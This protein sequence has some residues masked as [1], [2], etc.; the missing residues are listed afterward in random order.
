MYNLNLMI[1]YSISVINLLLRYI[2]MK[3]KINLLILKKN[4]KR[5]ENDRNCKLFNVYF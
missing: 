4:F 2:K 3:I 1:F 5:C